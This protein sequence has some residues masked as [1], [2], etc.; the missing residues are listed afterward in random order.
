MLCSLPLARLSAPFRVEMQLRGKEGNTGDCAL[1][2][3]AE[4]PPTNKTALSEPPGPRPSRDPRTGFPT[5]Y[6]LTSRFSQTL[7]PALTALKCHHSSLLQ[8]LAPSRIPVP[9][10]AGAHPWKEE[11]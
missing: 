5:A 10:T 8:S 3:Q 2:Y 9:P 6:G 7:R 1:G 11:G 4:L